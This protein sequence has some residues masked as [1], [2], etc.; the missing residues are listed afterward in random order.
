MNF[1][2][3][4]NWRFNAPSERPKSAFKDIQGDGKSFFDELVVDNWF[5]IEHMGD[6]TYWMRIGDALNIHVT[7]AEDG[8][9]EIRIDDYEGN[10]EVADMLSQDVLSAV[11][12]KL[13]S[14]EK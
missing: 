12:N 7:V 10:G 14:G 6:C 13:Y 1:P 3:G 9:C 5:H 8:K 11:I 2:L 4:Y